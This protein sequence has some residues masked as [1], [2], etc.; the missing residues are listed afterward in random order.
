[1]YGGLPLGGVDFGIAKNCYAMLRHD[2]QFDFY[3]GA[4]VDVTFMGAGQI[5]QYGNVNATKLGVRPTGAG[6]F[7]DITSN[8]KHVVFCSAFSSKGLELSLKDNKLQILPE[9]NIRK[10]VK[11]VEQ[12]SYNGKMARKRGQKMHFV[13]ERCVFE[14]REDG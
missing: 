14:L 12:V 6:G 9:G 3:N 1:M 5:D 7:V 4:G 13:T 2:D 10:C 8:S 11:N